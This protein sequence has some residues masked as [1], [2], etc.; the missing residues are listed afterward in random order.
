MNTFGVPVLQDR[1]PDYPDHRGYTRYLP[2]S[3]IA[4]VTWTVITEVKQREFSA[5]VNVQSDPVKPSG[6][7]HHLIASPDINLLFFPYWDMAF[8]NLLSCV[9]LEEI[10]DA[11]DHDR[12]PSPAVK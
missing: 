7:M 12:Y 5:L 10:F 3:A 1:G 6:L 8:L 9:L 11:K 4:D 2:S